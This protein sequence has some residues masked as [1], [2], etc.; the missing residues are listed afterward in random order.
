MMMQT[1]FMSELEKKPSLFCGLMLETVFCLR[2][3]FLYNRL[4]AA[5]FRF[6]LLFSLELFRQV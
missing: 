6:F 3:I 1:V 2:W 4:L 5:H